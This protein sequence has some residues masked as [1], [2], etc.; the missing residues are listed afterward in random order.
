MPE[1]NITKDYLE[2]RLNQ[3]AKQIGD[4]ISEAISKTLKEISKESDERIMKF[5]KEETDRL[6]K[7]L[8]KYESMT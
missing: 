6:M 4:N 8:G 7:A 3:F 2:K 1:E 5:E